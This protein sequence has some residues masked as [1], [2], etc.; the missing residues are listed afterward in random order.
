MLDHLFNAPQIKEKLKIALH[1]ITLL[2]LLF[3]WTFLK[4]VSSR[5][6]ED[7]TKW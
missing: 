6:N 1:A 5:N 2:N 4:V 3:Q 7:K